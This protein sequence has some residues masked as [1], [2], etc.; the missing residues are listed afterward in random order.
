MLLVSDFY[1][2]YQSGQYV[3][4]PASHKSV[5]VY[6]DDAVES[7]NKLTDNPGSYHGTR[8]DFK[9]LT[10]YKNIQYA[11]VPGVDKNYLSL[12]LYLPIGLTGKLPLIIQVHGGAWRMGDKKFCAAND[13]VSYGF[14]MACINYRL[15]Q[16]AKFPAQIYDV[17]SAVRWL[18]KN[19]DKYNLDVNRFG[20]WGDSAGGHLVALLGTSGGVSGLEGDI[21]VT[22]YSSKVQAVVDWFGP[23]DFSKVIPLKEKYGEY[24]DAAGQLLGGVGAKLEDVKKLIPEANPITYIDKNDPPFLIMHGKKDPTVM[25]NQSQL[26]HRAFKDKGVSSTLKLY[27]NGGDSM[28]DPKHTKEVISFFKKELN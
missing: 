13:V 23:T 25:F 19:A 6:I 21:G 12:D 5:N 9:N 4:Q 26:L 2:K 7:D 8:S 22:G 10:T 27:P 28:P 14:A 20:A 11:S 16:V 24:Y 15:S 17:K 3:S 18:R 1:G